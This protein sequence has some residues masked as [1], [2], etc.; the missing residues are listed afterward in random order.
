[1]RAL[2]GS[3]D[4]YYYSYGNKNGAST[5]LYTGNAMIHDVS[6]N[7]FMDAGEIRIKVI[8]TLN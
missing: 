8:N 1:M 4:A 7:R 2:G 3:L 5:V 6:S